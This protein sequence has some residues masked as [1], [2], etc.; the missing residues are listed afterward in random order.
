LPESPI[1]TDVIF[2][3]CEAGAVTRRA[4]KTN[5]ID[6]STY[7]LLSA[8]LRLANCKGQELDGDARAI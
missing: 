1:S 4:H 7:H 2:A 5:A 8:F 3:A 6:R